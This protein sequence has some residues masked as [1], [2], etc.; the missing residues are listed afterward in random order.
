MD[1]LLLQHTNIPTKCTDAPKKIFTVMLQSQ[2]KSLKESCMSLKWGDP[3]KLRKSSTVLELGKDLR[4]K[5]QK[6]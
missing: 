2:L 1:R 6:P 4:Q 3:R 5:N